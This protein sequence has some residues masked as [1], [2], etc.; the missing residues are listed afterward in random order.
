MGD[1]GG[2]LVACVYMELVGSAVE[3][4]GD[5]G[6]LEKLAFFIQLSKMKLECGIF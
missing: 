6:D 4:F 3:F 2:G 5:L 1:L